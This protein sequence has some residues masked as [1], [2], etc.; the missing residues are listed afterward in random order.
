MALKFEKMNANGDDFVIMDLRGSAMDIDPT[1]VSRMGDR[2]RGIGF[3]Q[4]AAISDCDDADARIHFWNPD[5]STLDA[6]GSATRG[7]A[8]KLMQEAGV[9]FVIVRTNRGL[10]ACRRESNEL[11]SVAMGKPH[12][13]WRDVPLSSELDTLELPLAGSP[14][15][16][17]MGNPHCT[18]FVG[19]VSQVDVETIGREIEN[20]PLFPLKTNVHF[21]EVIRRD[22]IRL[23]I[24]ERG[25]G[26]PL[27]SG[28][29][30]CGAV[31]NGIRRGFLDATVEVECDGGIVTVK[32]DGSG[33][34]FLSGPVT[35]V[36]KGT[37]L[38]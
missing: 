19:D 5:G 29:C 20:H 9:S 35:P 4:L 25:G 36:F 38:D 1:L 8:C 7:V 28:S 6:C 16:C 15:A 17:S 10:L 34:V 11:I 23:R 26:I 27:G 37:W 13:N 14:S 12:L 33:S 3:N 2:N 21:V 22:R 32:W 30:S 31:V 24:W 18:Y